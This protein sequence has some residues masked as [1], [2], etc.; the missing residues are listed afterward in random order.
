V[1]PDGTFVANWNSVAKLPDGLSK[2]TNVPDLVQSYVELQ[3]KLGGDKLPLPKDASDVEGWKTVWEKLGKPEKADD[4][5]LAKPE[6]LDPSL[7]SEDDAKAFQ[8]FAHAN[9]LLPAQAK[10][11]V[12][13]QASRT[14]AEVT[15]ATTAAQVQRAEAEKSLKAEWGA[16]F[17]ENLRLARHVA[18]LKFGPDFAEKNSALG[19]DPAFLKLLVMHGKAVGEKA[20]V[21]PQGGTTLNGYEAE[22]K[23]M[24]ADPKSALNNPGHPDYAAAVERHSQ[25]QYALFKSRSSSH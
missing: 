12:E 7:W 17:D 11:L 20:P 1:N 24:R 9:N 19:N 4:Y 3:K 14:I 21:N 2:F 13:W 23:A 10:A 16:E 25:L 5:A 15:A 8:Q 22:I 6:A 18:G